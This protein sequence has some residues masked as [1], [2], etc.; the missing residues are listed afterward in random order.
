M[1]SLARLSKRFR[2]PEQTVVWIL[3]SFGEYLR[4]HL[5]DHAKYDRGPEIY[6]KPRRVSLPFGKAQL[7][8]CLRV[9]VGGPLKW[10]A[11]IQ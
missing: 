3:V 1:P 10:D 2:A 8:R 9:Q 6:D 11:G 5:I 7:A 4:T